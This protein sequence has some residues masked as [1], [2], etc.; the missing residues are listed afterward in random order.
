MP[1][2]TTF[3]VTTASSQLSVANAGI[4]TV[5][6]ASLLASVAT[7]KNVSA[8]TVN[9]RGGV[10]NANIFIVRIALTN[11]DRFGVA[12]LSVLNSVL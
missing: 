10:T 5:T 4:P 3:S 2:A 6:T 7:V 1:S 12:F 11:R 9:Q 8:K